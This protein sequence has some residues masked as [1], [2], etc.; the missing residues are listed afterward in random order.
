MV[1]KVKEAKEFCFK[2]L[3]VPDEVREMLKKMFAPLTFITVFRADV[4]S[5]VLDDDLA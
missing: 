1:N 2:D 4:E 3:N 5:G